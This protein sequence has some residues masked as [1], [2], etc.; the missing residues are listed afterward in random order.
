MGHHARVSGAPARSKGSTQ[1][2]AD[3]PAGSR[4]AFALILALAMGT[5]TYAGYAFGVLGPSIIGEFTISRFQLGLLVDNLGSYT[6]AWLLV[7]A[8]F[9]ATGAVVLAWRRVTFIADGGG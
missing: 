3:R 5:S 2:W 7:A 1:A 6:L 9:A 4:A 8:V